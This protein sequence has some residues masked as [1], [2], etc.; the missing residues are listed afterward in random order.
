MLDSIHAFWLF[1]DS[2]NKL[3]A[4]QR[5]Q[6]VSLVVKGGSIRSVVEATGIAKNTVTR[7]LKD[8]GRACLLYQD[9]VFQRLTC[10]RIQCD[11]VWSFVG[12]K[13]VDDDTKRRRR[14]DY[15]TWIALDPDTKLVPCWYVGPR[16][17]HA[18]YRFFHNLGHRLE[19]RIGLTVHGH[20]LYIPT[21][22]DTV[23]VIDYSI[24]IKI[25]GEEKK[26]GAYN[27]PELPME[28]RHSVDSGKPSYAC[29]STGSIEPYNLTLRPAHRRL[30]QSTRGFSK[31][32]ENH[33]YALSLFFCHY[34][35]A[36]IHE[37]LQVT[38]A[39]KAG[40]LNRAW[41]IADLIAL[42]DSEVAPTK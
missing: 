2:M 3:T 9:R 20:K 19:H 41:D 18:G 1:H 23:S 4:D 40:V 35:F 30:A 12:K 8:V 37:T 17:A 33:W 10:S 32:I 21:V 24:L 34:N 7:L 25:Y 11:E 15:W 31:K 5:I 27:S 28:G 6:V 26:S 38:P 36:K 42:I 22:E 14:G 39:M 13:S 29:D 16:D